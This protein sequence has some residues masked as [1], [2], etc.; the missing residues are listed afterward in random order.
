MIHIFTCDM[1]FSFMQQFPRMLRATSRHLL[2][3]V[4][5]KTFSSFSMPAIHNNKLPKFFLHAINQSINEP[6]LH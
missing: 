1:H 5:D 3:L 6:S 4:V 2:S